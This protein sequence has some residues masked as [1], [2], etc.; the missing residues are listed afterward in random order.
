MSSFLGSPFSTTLVECARYMQA[1]II[2]SSYKT[3][4]KA[5]PCLMV[6]DE[7]VSRR[8]TSPE[9]VFSRAKLK[10]HAGIGEV[11]LGV[12]GDGGDPANALSN[13]ATIRAARPGAG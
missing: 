11:F 6:Q 2:S 10:Q 13:T 1:N 9:N 5:K 3:A 7:M 12:H 4:L 8:C